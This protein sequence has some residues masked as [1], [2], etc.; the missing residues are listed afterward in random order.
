VADNLA[1]E[2]RPAL[3]LDADKA[4]S[5]LD[6][7]DTLETALAPLADLLAGNGST[8]SDFARALEATVALLRAAPEDEAAAPLEGEEELARWFELAA[9]QGERGPRL[10]PEAL[11]LALDGLFAGQNVRPRQVEAEDVMIFGRLEAR[12]MDA[13]RVILAVM[14][15]SVW[16]EIADPGRWMSRGMR[17]AV[18]LGP[19]EK[20]HGLA[21][22]DSPMAAGG[23]EVVFTLPERSG[24]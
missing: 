11:P 17:L 14:I 24:T 18:G 9:R 8:A 15:E 10:V 2:G 16:P 4:Q 22:H 5:V 21:A 19:P 20:L 23:P 1:G 13:D 12:L 6:L 3:R 7:I